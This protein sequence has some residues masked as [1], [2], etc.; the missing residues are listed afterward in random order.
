[1]DL[2]GINRKNYETAVRAIS[3]DLIFASIIRQMSDTQ[4]ENIMAEI[5]FMADSMTSPT[6]KDVVND[7]KNTIQSA[8]GNK[9]NGE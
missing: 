5:A 4:R 8:L 9:Q 1:M 2:V 7:I 6:A 3:H